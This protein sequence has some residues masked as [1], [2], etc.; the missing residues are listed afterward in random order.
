MQ[1][2]IQRHHELYKLTGS[3]TSFLLFQLSLPVDQMR[4]R[5]DK[6][7][8]RVHRLDTEAIRD[9]YI[10]VLSMVTAQDREKQAA[11]RLVDIAIQSK[12]HL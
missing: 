8:D 9:I 3:F 1:Y 6:L 12:I 11:S 2:I 10:R 7:I 5:L 4:T